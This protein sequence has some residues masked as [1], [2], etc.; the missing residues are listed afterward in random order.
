MRDTEVSV[1]LDE[2]I[3][4]HDK[5]REA[6]TRKRQSPFEIVSAVVPYKRK[7]QFNDEVTPFKV[8]RL[9]IDVKVVCDSMLLGNTQSL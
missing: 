8:P 5:S 9:A 2:M 6:P 7:S 3:K 4:Q 1:G